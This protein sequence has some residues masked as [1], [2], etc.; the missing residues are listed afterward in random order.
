MK[1]E[2]RKIWLLIG[3]L[4]IC[5]FYGWGEVFY[6]TGAVGDDNWSTS[7]NWDSS[8]SS[9]YYPGENDPM[10]TVTIDPGYPGYIGGNPVFDIYWQTIEI[11]SL[12]ME[13]GSVLD[14]AGAGYSLTVQ[15][16]VDLH[17]DLH[18][19]GGTL[20]VGG[21]IG[22]TGSLT[23]GGGFITVGGSWDVADMGDSSADVSFTGS[24]DI[25]PHGQTFGSVTIS[26]G[27]AQVY[28][29]TGT[30]PLQIQNAFYQYSGILN[31][32]N[33]A[34]LNAISAGTGFSHSGGTINI[35]NGSNFTINVSGGTATVNQSTTAVIASTGSGLLTVT[36]LYGITL[37]GSN[38]I[39]NL[40]LKLTGTVTGRSITYR[41]TGTTALNVSASNVSPSGAITINSTNVSSNVTIRT[42][43]ISS[44]GGTVQ[45]NSSGSITASNGVSSSNGTITL[46]GTA[47]VTLNAGVNAGTGSIT[48]QAGSGMVSQNGSG[49]L[50]GNALT[51]YALNGISLNAATNLVPTISLTNGAG[52]GTNIVFKNG[53]SA[54]L[55][56]A[57]NN[58][59]AGII[60]I[61]Q[62]GTLTVNTGGIR[63]SDGAITLNG[64]NGVTL[65]GGVDSGAGGITLQTGNGSIGQNAS[66]I[67]TGTSLTAS[68]LNGISLNVATNMVSNASFTN[69]AGINAN[70]LF[71]NGSS[72][73]S[74]TAANQ[75][76]TGGINIE[77]S[78][79]L[80]VTTGGVGSVNGAVTL[81][82]ANGVAINNPVGSGAAGI[83]L[84]AAN[85]TVSQIAGGTITGNSLMVT[86]LNGITLNTAGSNSVLNA[87]LN[88]TSTTSGA[89]VFANN[90][91][92]TLNVQGYNN[93]SGSSI[94]ITDDTKIVVSGA[95]TIAN[96]TISL[97]ADDM[98][99]NAAVNAGTGTNSMVQ[100]K[101]SDGRDIDIGTNTSGKLG[102]STADFQR[103]T[104]RTLDIGHTA[105]G[106]IT[107]SGAFQNA[108]STVQTLVLRTGAGVTV[109]GMGGLI[110]VPN[111]AIQANNG[112]DV[113]VTVTNI[114]VSSQTGGIKITSPAQGFT[115]AQVSDISGLTCA[116][117]SQ[118][119]DLAAAGVVTQT[120]PVN[121]GPSA[122]TLSLGGTGGTYTFM[123]TSNRVN[124]L[125]SGASNP[126]SISYTNNGSFTVGNGT[127]GITTGGAVTLNT[128]TATPQ[129]ITVR[130]TIASG[131]GIVTGGAIN[132]STGLTTGS[133]ILGA[134]INSGGTSNGGAI[135]LGRAV[136]LTNNATVTTGTGTGNITFS[137]TIQGAYS[138]TV[139]AGTGTAIFNNSIGTSTPLTSIG[140]SGGTIQLAGISINTQG[141]INFTGPV[142]L[143]GGTAVSINTANNGNVAFSSTVTGARNLSITANGTGQV[144]FN[145]GVTVGFSVA[146]ALSVTAQTIALGSNVILST[147]GVNGNITITADAFTLGGTNSVNA[148]TGIFQISPRTAGYTVEYGPSNSTGATVWYS[149]GWTSIAAGSFIIGNSTHQGNIT[150]SNISGA[151]YPLTVTNSA[152]TGTNG[153]ITI[154]NN[155]SS[156]NRMLT[157]NAGAG[158]VVLDG[159]GGTAAIDLG[160]VTGAPFIVTGIFKLKD[161][162]AGT[163]TAIGVSG[164]FQGI[165]LGGG[166]AVQ[167]GGAKDLTLNAGARNITITGNVGTNADR[168][169]TMMINT[170][171]TSITSFNTTAAGQFYSGNFDFNGYALTI[172]NS[173]N[174]S[175]ATTITN[176]GPFVTAATGTITS[177]GGFAQDGLGV[178][179][180]GANI[181]VTDTAISFVTAVTLNTAGTV[182][183]STGAGTPGNIQF[184]STVNASVANSSGL[185]LTAGT[186]DITITGAL[187]NT[188]RLGTLTINSVKDAGFSAAVY[189]VNFTQTG[190]TGTTTFSAVQNYTGAFSFTGTN[191]T[192]NEAMAVTGS[193]TITNSGLFTKTTTGVIT[194]T[195]G[196]TQDGLGT[197]RIG[198][199]ITTSNAVILFTG[200]IELTNTVSFTTN[201]GDITLTGALTRDSTARS[202]TLNAG[203]GTVQ[204]AAMG[205]DT[206]AGRLINIIIYSG[207]I[208]I[209]GSLCASG[210]IYIYNTGLL[211]VNNPNG[212]LYAQGVLRVSGNTQN[213]GIIQAG[214]VDSSI[215]AISFGGNYANNAAAPFGSLRGNTTTNPII[216]FKGN[217]SFVN[218]GT[219]THNNGAV[220]FNGTS[221]D[222]ALDVQGNTFYNVVINKTT[223]SVKLNNSDVTQAGTSLSLNISQ[224]T[225]DLNGR[226]WRM[227]PGAGPYT[228][229]FT[230]ITGELVLGAGAA[231]SSGGFVTNGSGF[232]VT[233]VN[234]SYITASGSI[235][236]AD[237]T[238]GTLSNVSVIMTGTGNLRLPSV[239]AGQYQIYNLT[240]DG[241]AVALTNDLLVGNDI[242]IK[243]VGSLDVAS[244]YPV[245]LG[246]GWYQDNPVGFNPRQGTVR[247]TAESL[248][249]NIQ[250]STTWYDFVC[251]KDLATIRFSKNPDMHYVK[252]QMVIKASSS[253]NRITLTKLLNSQYRP[254]RTP[255]STDG[256]P[257][258]P[259]P[260]L[261]AEHNYFWNFNLDASGS[262]DF[263]NV[264]VHYSYAIPP[265]RTIPVMSSTIWA[266][267]YA[268]YYN[269]RWI[270]GIV[271]VYSFA[272]DS[273]GN[274]RIDRIRVQASTNVGDDFSGFQVKV[275]GYNLKYPYY[276]RHSTDFDMIYILLEEKPYAD[277][278]ATP[279]WYIVSNT[280]LRDINPGNTLLK[281]YGDA[282]MVPV[283]TV[284]PRINYSLIL[285][286][287]NELFIQMTE[288]VTGLSAASDISISGAAPLV[289]SIQGITGSGGYYSEYKV[290]LDTVIS[291]S[292]IAYDGIKFNLTSPGSVKDKKTEFDSVDP[293]Y[294][295][296]K[297]P[298]NWNYG[299]YSSANPAPEY[300]VPAAAGISDHRITDMLV[301]IEPSSPGDNR[302]FVWPVWAMD[303]SESI[304][305][306]SGYDAGL[307][308][309]FD[310]TQRLRDTDITMEVT[311]GPGISAP[312][313]I[314]GTNV[315]GSYRA[316]SRNGPEGLWLPET[317]GL[318]PTGYGE[319]ISVPGTSMGG[320]LYDFNLSESYYQ[321]NSNLEFFFKLTGAP[322]NLSA[323]YLSI[324]AGTST[325][326]SNW[327]R[328]VKPFS[329]E[330]KDLTLQRGGATILNNVIDPTKGEK[331]YLNYTMTK[332]GRV[333]V[334]VFTMDGTLVQVLYRGSRSTG[335]YIES[336]DGK[337][338]GGRPVARGMYFIRIVGPDIDEIRKVMV[339]RR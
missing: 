229:G 192:M 29:L 178:N 184:G 31:I 253:A 89:V 44:S 104:A 70:I 135:T 3:I 141:N 216:E 120:M 49:T 203:A 61:E 328:R 85:G 237:G 288:P 336:W 188:S 105:A 74:M 145:G 320:G 161:L 337:N 152:G 69:G 26:T 159:G 166:I 113:N 41:Q 107:L 68:A 124:V 210:Y 274:G 19:N 242:T 6:W 214:P 277:G 321:T 254:A 140:I 295:A 73:L 220:H 176:S 268:T 87:T 292:Q 155:Y 126:A 101:A 275:D 112:V 281:T 10:D 117:A 2:L 23:A 81:N 257:S 35:Q 138:L 323:G 187:G 21:D 151:T 122:G 309:D 202:I 211:T 251:E 307:I 273:N 42:G 297:Y 96:G 14:I 201:N 330:I 34:S 119:I 45:V 48:L 258:L 98:D 266:T 205:T 280:T 173:I 32:Q 95:L 240:V 264:E 304:K 174:V 125:I 230:G 129:V 217:V 246:G 313:M 244:D 153:T 335:E 59:P 158:G 102:L 285:P 224:G 260:N 272:E 293:G 60:N 186:G 318:V 228:T 80:T 30:N 164:T 128:S 58:S 219:F 18:L 206:A 33:S 62:S 235:N 200:S 278:N 315:P 79:T 12:T 143:T 300:P 198:S 139:T 234:P 175:G 243:T 168:V 28:S 252:N 179:S 339:I 148:G 86:A 111:L 57:V 115:I 283:D 90:S 170:A 319:T 291:V 255:D 282:P 310:G 103:V 157:L 231:L 317:L 262:I 9:G 121:A 183:F 39:Q 64:V 236:V 306:S 327:Y 256:N 13:T 92:S 71:R 136:T 276:E 4:C 312:T 17:G 167:G 114:A 63:S 108:G 144:S 263:D 123:N 208:T 156:Q 66:G 106:S 215:V 142:Q 223:G 227:N 287:H 233:A 325:I 76:S 1:A 269:L 55:A 162:T 238:A 177:A 37:N 47:G 316:G 100:L 249:V 83:I 322:F 99:F 169:G 221:G 331:A 84:E 88:K 261:P 38:N 65:N 204:T 72:A 133:I 301:S 247:F 212:G 171:G 199:N 53:T 232:T 218:A 225:L 308:R 196:F 259:K 130:N 25:N 50:T 40:D 5:S 265:G 245:T 250:G 43:G 241:G 193:T 239:S 27:V 182:T 181:T 110:T 267:P 302:Y 338:K 93:Y 134:D 324:P 20:E 137:N 163:I 146:G 16:N 15:G 270:D 54:L 248:I 22:G 194:A 303:K 284:W 82:G 314:F 311:V 209:N 51:V 226:S 118:T 333:T 127:T 7:G 305:G 294:D 334:Q 160:T 132:I 36:S 271:F 190:G 195:G 131:S 52:A 296:P 279:S 24:G 222:Q 97:T 91:G 154:L 150:V 56:T 329:F 180:I 172:N 165:S 11:A 185:T 46:N 77:Q 149:S 197:N 332:S 191:L 67:L 147:I 290:I 326:P 298:L 213:R 75:S 289:T 109:T 207:A 94:T 286:G 78:G 8:D 189:A 299:S 116:A